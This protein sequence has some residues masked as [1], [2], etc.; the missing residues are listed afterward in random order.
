MSTL[1]ELTDNNFDSEVKKSTTP[2]LVDFWAPWC[3]PCRAVAPLLEELAAEYQGRVVVAKINV[4]ENQSIPAR[5]GVRSI[6]SI[7]VIKDG[8]EI[9]RIVGARP[10]NDFKAILDPL[11]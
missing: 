7:L 11:V 10:K 2:M 9:N 5:F 8:E 4:D 3:G 6:P 1:L